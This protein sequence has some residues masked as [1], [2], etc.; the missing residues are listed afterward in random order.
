M[1]NSIIVAIITGTLTLT[2][3]VIANYSMRKK[4]AIA[5][6]V[7]DQKIEDK[8]QALSDRVDAHN[9]VMDKVANIEK[10][11]VRIETKLEGK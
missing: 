5:N 8:L 6:A 11:I 7:R 10:S 3:T 9:G 1:D 2:G 4:D